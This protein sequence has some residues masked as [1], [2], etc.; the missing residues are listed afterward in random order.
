MCSLR[1]EN[2]LLTIEGVRFASISKKTQLS[3]LSLAFVLLALPL[4]V[5]TY[6]PLPARKRR[7]MINQLALLKLPTFCCEKEELPD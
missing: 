3:K 7:Y 5:R 1:F 4:L 6:Q 2:N